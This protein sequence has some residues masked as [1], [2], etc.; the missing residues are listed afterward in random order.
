MQLTKEQIDVAWKAIMNWESY[1][2][3]W[4]KLWVDSWYLR[5]ILISNW[6]EAGDRKE[7][8]WTATT[9]DE[10]IAISKR[11][12][13]WESSYSSEAYNLWISDNGLKKRMK[14]AWI[15]IKPLQFES[16]VVQCDNCWADLFK[17][18]NRIHKLNY[19]NR[20][21]QT[22][23]YKKKQHIWFTI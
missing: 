4:K 2:S 23:W 14:R 8:S 1:Y 21:C 7:I 9:N 16:K 17:E 5:R 10:L 19:C 18:H 20:D 6:Y 13:S 22:A 11:I 15:E 3:R 12:Y